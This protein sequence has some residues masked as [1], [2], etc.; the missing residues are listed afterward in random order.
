TPGVVVASVPWRLS[1]SERLGDREEAPPPALL[2]RIR[3]AGAED[4]AD[5]DDDGRDPA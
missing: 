4:T 3:G 5:H 2:R 1:S